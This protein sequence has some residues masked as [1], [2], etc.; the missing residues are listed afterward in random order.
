MSNK[1]R[2]VLGIL[3][4]LAAIFLPAIQERI[5]DITP[6]PDDNN[7]I[8]PSEEILEKVSSIAD[9]VTDD[10]DRVDMFAFNKVFSER[11]RSYSVDAQQINDIYTEAGK[12]FFKGR[13]KGKYEGLS[14]SLVG[15]MSGVI[16]IENHTITK[17][18]KEKL[19][20]HFDG[21]SWCFR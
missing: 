13:L 7:V 10:K 17:E 2:L 4:I 9:K 8:I 21:L 19:A 14:D 12:I 15:L 18:E 20:S 3:V 5:P 16:G 11:L 1:T 6:K